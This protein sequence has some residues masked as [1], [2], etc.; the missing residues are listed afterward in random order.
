MIVLRSLDGTCSFF[1]T[2]ARIQEA[3][4]AGRKFPVMND[5]NSSTLFGGAIGYVLFGYLMLLPFWA[6][7]RLWNVAQKSRPVNPWILPMVWMIFVLA[8][9]LHHTSL[10]RTATEEDLAV[11]AG[12][13][14]AALGCVLAWRKYRKASDQPVSVAD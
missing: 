1:A 13:L 11:V 14:P 7:G 2:R 3:R 8:C 6:V 12:L 10:G 4:R 5:L 9:F